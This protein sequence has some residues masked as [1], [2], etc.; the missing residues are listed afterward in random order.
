M[1]DFLTRRKLLTMGAV[2]VGGLS[3]SG[4][5]PLTRSKE[6]RSFLHGGEALTM[7]AQRALMAGQPLAREFSERDLSRV[8]KANGTKNPDTLAYNSMAANNFA[9]WR[10]QIDGLVEKPQSFTLAELRALPSRTQI[11]RHDC[12]EGWSA[13]GKWKGVQLS[14]ILQSVSL[15]PNARFAVF[16]CA[17]NYGGGLDAY[18]ESV[19]LID[20]FH[21]Q[22]ILAYDMNDRPLE[23]AHG[24]PLRMRIERQ[25]GYKHAK[26]VMRIEIVD[27]FARIGRGKGGFWEDRGYEWYAGI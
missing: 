4:C 21:P 15:K 2:T 22:T 5:D 14:A 25:L 3:L 17:D 1:K 23:I 10:L 24:A 6:F 26:Y 19:D 18:Y 8:F 13:I 11:T 27:S 16:H 7:S 9:D 20:A 12:V